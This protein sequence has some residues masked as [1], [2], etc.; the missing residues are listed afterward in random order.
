MP[1]RTIDASSSISDLDLSQDL[2]VVKAGTKGTGIGQQVVDALATS[3]GLS[4]AYHRTAKHR[5]REEAGDAQ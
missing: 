5:V 1:R 3:D 4:R 2:T